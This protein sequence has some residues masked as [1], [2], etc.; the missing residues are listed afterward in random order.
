[1]RR[2]FLSALVL[3]LL[4]STA[5]A[6]DPPHS[7]APVEM[8]GLKSPA[9]IT[10]DE[11]GIFHVRAG[12][13]DDLYFLNGWVHA[14]DRLFQMD[15]NRRLASGTLAEILGPAA[16]ESD[17]QLRTIGL[18]RAA[19]RSLTALSPDTQQ[20]L[21]AYARGVN[22]WVAANPLPPEY[23]D[24]ELTK[25]EPWTA[26][27]TVVVG[28]LIAFGLSFDLD[29]DRTIAFETYVAAGLALGFDGVALFQE[30]LDRS[31]PF[32]SAATV[33]DASVPTDQPKPRPHPHGK[34]DEGRAAATADA[35]KKS[36]LR[37]EA[38]QLGHDYLDKVRR[39]PLFERILDRNK[40]DGSNL[41][42]VSGDLT[43]SGRPLVANDPHLQ[44]G[45]PSTFYPMG[46]EIPG[47]LEVFGS[48]FPGVAGIVQGY[49]RHISWGT[50][51]NAIDVT[52][53]FQEQ[54][55]PDPTSPSGLSTVYQ[56]K[57]EPILPIPETFRANQLGNKVL[58]DVLVEPPGG[59]I[60]PFTLIVPRRNFGPIVELVRPTDV[61]AGFALSVQYTGFSPTRELDTFLQ[62]NHA[63][64]LDEF[65]AALQFLD[66]GSQNFVY[67]DDRG[68]IAYFTTGEMP[69][70]EDLQAGDVNGLPPWF[71]RNGQGGNEWLPVQHPQ[72][73][74]AVPYEVLPFSEMP[75][76]VNPAAGWLVN[77]NNDPAGLTL[78]ND[79]LDQLRPGG[80]I[81]YLA[82]A[83]DRGY[84][85]GRIT[86]RLDEYLS[87]RG[88]RMSFE[89]MQAIQADVVL[90]DAEYFT[91]WIVQAFRRARTKGA[92]PALAAFASDPAMREAVRRF[93]AWD[94]ST[95]TGLQEGWDAG[96]PA[97]ERPR[98]DSIRD[99]VAASIYAAWRSRFV[100]NTVDA[101]LAELA[102]PMI[103]Q[104][105]RRLRAI[106]R[107]CPRCAT[108]STTSARGRARALPA[109][110]SSPFPA[111]TTPTTAATSSSSRASRM[112]S[113][114]SP[115]MPSSRRSRT[116]P[117]RT[118]IAGA[119]CTASCSAIPSAGRSRF[120]LPAARSSRRWTGWTAFRPTAAS[121]PSTRRPTRCAPRMRMAS[122]SAPGRCAASSA[123]RR[124]ARRAPNRSGREGRA[125]FSA[126]RSTSSSWRNGWPTK[127]FLCCWAAAKCA[128]SPRRSRSSCR[129]RHPA[130]AR[131]RRQRAKQG[132]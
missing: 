12:N 32:D 42:A 87:R 26:L 56:G 96:K 24:L 121:R 14:R 118:T 2:I 74:Q 78:D 129:L 108:C 66:F 36:G 93:T 45:T 21:A 44:L 73:H 16:L 39:I 43:D 48:G 132:V 4:G 50:T 110:T 38:M 10:R 107:C 62:I 25:F 46:L 103:R 125:E 114:F 92:E 59:A 89:K 41:W 35:M 102:G 97:G 18:R 119:S 82:Y 113:I 69:V 8:A 61:E 115:A 109:S 64:N 91:P 22:A 6:G 88:G 5:W 111:S 127:P 71:V 40:R 57:L 68:N 9:Q 76:I 105:R 122:C 29:I 7:A 120:R 80:G 15:N 124:R 72:P 116:P 54:V 47:R 55:V 60:P 106:R 112:R 65:K 53:T 95:P 58:D 128:R 19:Q 51:N 49:N 90:R 30:D 123:S 84:R 3:L 117:I 34:R 11:D 77:A 33:P 101:A 85:A 94:R 28:K 1:M 130:A 100:A 86:Q 131:T 52:D 27:D 67:G 126:A 79:P 23:A 75:Q 104:S 70:R 37:H 81:Y 17:V 98:L 31:A 83:W 99:S 63:K 13:A 20:A